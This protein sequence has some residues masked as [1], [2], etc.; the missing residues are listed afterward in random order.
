[1]PAFALNCDI[2][3]PMAL[4]GGAVYAVDLFADVLV[5]KD[6]VSPDLS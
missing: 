1:V 6:G 5:R 4:Q 3:T 2:A